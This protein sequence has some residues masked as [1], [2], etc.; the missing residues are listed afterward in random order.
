MVIKVTGLPGPFLRRH[1]CDPSFLQKSDNLFNDGVQAFVRRVDH[2][3]R[4]FRFFIGRRYAGKFF[5]F[6]SSP[7]D[8]P[9]LFPVPCGLHDVGEIIIV[10][11]PLEHIGNFFVLRD[12]D[13]RIAC[14]SP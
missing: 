1:R 7:F 3:I 5:Y 4:S 11:L 8:L 9:L 14:T 10:R 12:Q 6:S 2:Q 13:R